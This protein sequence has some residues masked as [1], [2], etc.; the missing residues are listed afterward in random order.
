VRRLLLVRHAPT[1]ATRGFAFPAD[2]PLLDTGPID[3]PVPPRAEV[4]RSPS[5]RCAQTA[6][7][8]GLAVD[9]VEPRI[10]ECDFGTWSGRTLAEIEPPQA[11]L[12]MSDPDAAPHGGEC[13]RDFAARVAAWLDEQAALDGAAVAI[14]HGGVIKAAVIHALHAPIESFWRVD[15]SPLA[16]TELHAHRERWTLT[17]AN[18]AL[19]HG[20]APRGAAARG[21][22]G[23]RDAAARGDGPATRPEAA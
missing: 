11:R 20:G 13:L 16:I 8:A 5:L 3:L 18:A 7:A 15:A 2:E 19:P 10:A 6:E 21:D 9:V 1:S 23:R 14:T 12:W 4:I 22:D 17:R